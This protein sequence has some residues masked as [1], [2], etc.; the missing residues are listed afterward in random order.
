MTK[1]CVAYVKCE[2]NGRLRELFGENTYSS[3]KKGLGVV[4]RVVYT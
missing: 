3:V 4:Q 2:E 1:V